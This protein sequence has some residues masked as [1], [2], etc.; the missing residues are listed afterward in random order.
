MTRTLALLVMLAAVGLGAQSAVTPGGAVPGPLPLF[1]ADNWWNQDISGA[2]LDPQS[3]AYIAFIGTTRRAHPDFGGY[4]SPGSAGIYGFPYVVVSGSQPKR[5]VQFY[6]AD[7]SDGVDHGTGQSYPFYPIPD[8][9]ITQPYFIEGGPPGNQAPGGD[10]HML[11]LDRDNR[12]LY[13]LYDLRWTGTGWSAGSGASFDLGQNGRRPEGWTSADAAGLA[14]LPGLVRY[15][16]VFGPDEI[17]HAFRVTVRATNGYVWPASH[18]AGSTAG[19]LPLGARLRLK[20]STNLAGYPAEVQKIFRAMQRYGLIVADNGSDLYVSGAFDARW[21]N[22][23]LNP[24]FH[25]LH[26]SDFEVVQ[27]GWRGGAAP[28]ESPG[29]PVGFGAAVTGAQV[30]FAW[31][32][33]ASGGVVVGYRLEAGSAPGASDIATVSVGAAR[34]LVATAPAG[35]YYTRV[36]ATNACGTGAA[37]DEAQVVIGGCG[38]PGVAGPVTATVTGTT[39]RLSWPAVTGASDYVLEVG[40]APGL[41]DLLVSGVPAPGLSASAPPGAYFVRV[42]A[43]N[44]C[45][46][47]AASADVSVVVP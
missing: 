11:L 24:A 8:E 2:P 47:G 42:R 1:P 30:Q 37:S 44:A 35:T 32:A 20:A 13:E 5:A 43:R 31:Q 39:V 40:S 46:T 16:E 45:G 17:R 18:R 23:I 34:T 26:A 28:C 12:H 25:A 7:E 36:R 21:N 22:D 3:A 6:Y 14:I 41:S 19:A 9:A 38:A 15:D 27:L 33:P 4:E 29:A 10:R